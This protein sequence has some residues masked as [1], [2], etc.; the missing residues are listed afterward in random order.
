M[1]RLS[2]LVAS[3][4]DATGE[5]TASVTVIARYLREA[6]LI[7]TGGRGLSAARMTSHDLASLL[8][9]MTSL[10]DNTK[11]GETVALVG[12]ML[13]EPMAPT[14]DRGKISHGTILIE[15]HREKLG[16]EVNMSLRDCLAF[17]IDRYSINP[18]PPQ[19]PPPKPPKINPATGMFKIDRDPFTFRGSTLPK[20]ISIK[21]GQSFWGWEASRCNFA[22]ATA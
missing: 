22:A 5:T 17:Q 21:V 7:T 12:Q 6:G 2:D 13:L 16:L 14:N 9:A 20:S 15:E 3:V 18:E 1:A 19:E 10:G 11:A 8:L 4:A